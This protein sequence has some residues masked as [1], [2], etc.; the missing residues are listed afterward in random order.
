[1]SDIHLEWEKTF[2]AENKSN[3]DVL[4]VAG[5][6]SE[7]YNKY[8]FRSFL[9][10]ALQEFED[11]IFILGNHEYYMGEISQVQH[12]INQFAAEYKNLHFLN[13]NTF[14]KDN[15][16]FI[17]TTLWTDLNK[18]DYFAQQISKRSLNDYNYIIGLNTDWWMQENRIAKNYIQN[19]IANIHQ[20]LIPVV[21][22]HHSPSFITLDPRYKNNI[23]LNYSYNCTDLDNFILNSNIKYWFYGHTHCSQKNDMNGTSLICNP[24]GYGKENSCFNTNMTVKI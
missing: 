3:A 9:L 21:I 4:I 15:V 14:I 10:K 17:G 16:L 22:T 11:V 13:N 1:M 8:L 7:W 12:E 20:S 23:E 24:K 19:T 18:G 6:T 2:R 5:D